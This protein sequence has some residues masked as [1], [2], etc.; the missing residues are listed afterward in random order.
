MMLDDGSFVTAGAEYVHV[1]D[2]T[3]EMNL[4]LEQFEARYGSGR[5]RP[6]ETPNQRRVPAAASPR[7]RAAV[8]RAAVRA[9]QRAAEPDRRTALQYLESFG[10]NARNGRWEVR[11]AGGSR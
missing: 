1:I 2:G 7:E 8:S 6:A 5:T 11:T 3:A 4:G 9:S 10:K